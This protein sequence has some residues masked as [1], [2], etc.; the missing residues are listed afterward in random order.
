M[1]SLSV[2][3][4]TMKCNKTENIY[5]CS[6]MNNFQSKARR[7]IKSINRCEKSFCECNFQC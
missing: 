2:E 6:D 1:E 7:Q 4:Q 3:E 5:D